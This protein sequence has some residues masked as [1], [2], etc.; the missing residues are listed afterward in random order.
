MLHSLTIAPTCRFRRFPRRGNWR[1]RGGY[2][3]GTYYRPRFHTY[4][5]GGGRGRGRGADFRRDD[6]RRF[7]HEWRDNRA[8]GGR[9]FRPRRGGGGRG[10]PFR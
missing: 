4:N 7:Q 2:E 10:R 8:R 9:P 1:G 6:G 5:G 3:R